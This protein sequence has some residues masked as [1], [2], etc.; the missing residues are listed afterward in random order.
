LK[1]LNLQRRNGRAGWLGHGRRRF[2]GCGW[3]RPRRGSLCRAP[4]ASG[5]AQVGWGRRQQV[6]R[7]GSR[8][9]GAISWR[10]CRAA[11][12]DGRRAGARGAW[13]LGVCVAWPRAES[14]GGL[15][16]SLCALTERSEGERM[17]RRERIGE[18]EGHWGWRRLGFPWWRGC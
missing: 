13:R 12:S 8:G 16:G 10:S 2:F 18:G 7:R 3:A 14:R 15:A 5:R 11:R 4:G 1:L 17:E 9:V 6:R